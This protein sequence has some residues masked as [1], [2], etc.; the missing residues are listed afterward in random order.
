M[1][2]GAQHKYLFWTSETITNP[3]SSQILDK[4]MERGVRVVG[5]EQGREDARG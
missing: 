2:N 5:R 4:N 1:E 3:N